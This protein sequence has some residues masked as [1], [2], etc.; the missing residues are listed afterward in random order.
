MSHKVLLTKTGAIAQIILNDPERLNALSF[1]MAEEFSKIVTQVKAAPELRCVLLTGA[2]RAFSAG[3]NLKMIKEKRSKSLEINKKE[4]IKFYGSFLCLR[5]IP[6]PTIAVLN[7]PAI[8][9]GFCVALA[10]DLRMA[11]DQAKLGVNFVKLGLSPGMAGS[12]LI[13]QLAGLPAAA[14]L[15][16]TG[17]TV[18]ASEAYRLGLINQVYPEADLSAKA[19][20]LAE[21]IASNGP[22]AVR[23]AKKLLYQ[24]AALPLK[25]AL[26][27]EA[28]AQARCFQTDDLTE[29]VAAI[30]EKRPPQFKG[31]R[32]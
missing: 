32:G 7:G 13:T 1:E 16:L 4:M 8:G 12:W 9:A 11:S 27:G 6:I 31:N 24:N 25:Q 23:E 19:R 26:A 21:A 29:G 15:V 14:D 30:L 20:G 10:C 2:G 18:S 17:R 28:E 22:V 5:E 3:G